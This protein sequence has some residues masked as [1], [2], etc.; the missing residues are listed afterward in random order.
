M[1]GIYR[2]PPHYWNHYS[3]VPREKYYYSYYGTYGPDTDLSMYEPIAE[4]TIQIQSNNIE[5][6]STSG[7]QNNYGTM[8]MCL[9][10]AWILLKL[11]KLI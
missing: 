5:N 8:I 1:K 3:L 4:D 2:G 6:F 10:L 11:L 9:A 7:N